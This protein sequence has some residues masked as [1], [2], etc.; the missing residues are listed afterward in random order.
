MAES[1]RGLIP[2]TIPNGKSRSNK[3]ASGLA[4][5]LKNSPIKTPRILI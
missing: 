4:A 5:Y 2:N 1:Q 3:R